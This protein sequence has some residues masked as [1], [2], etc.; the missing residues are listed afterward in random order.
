MAPP[1]P[2]NRPGHVPHH[3][4]EADSHLRQTF[5]RDRRLLVCISNKETEFR[6]DLPRS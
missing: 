3:P 5:A 1:A 4:E 2:S 6:E